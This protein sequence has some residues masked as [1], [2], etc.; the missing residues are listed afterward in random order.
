MNRSDPEQRTQAPDG[1]PLEEQPAWRG[2]FPIDWSQDTYVARREFTKF[3]VLTSFAFFVGQ[4]CIG[5][6]NWLQHNRSKP[7]RAFL[8]ELDKVPVGGTYRFHYPEKHEPCLLLRPNADQLVAYDQRCTHLS[9]DVIPQWADKLEDCRLHCPC[10]HGYFDLATGRPVA[11][12][13][14]RPL[15]RITLEV[16]NGKVYATGVEERTV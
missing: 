15:N 9:C 4:I 8:I 1:R 5:V 3:M 7:A 2:D 13:P 12:P 6:R 10:H 16:D 11:G 14:R